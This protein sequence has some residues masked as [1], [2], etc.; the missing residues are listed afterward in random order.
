M[1]GGLT[2]GVCTADDIHIFVFAGGSFSVGRAVVDASTGE[3]VHAGDVQATPLHARRDH[4]TVANQFLPGPK[5]DHTILALH[6]KRLGL[7]RGKNFRAEPFDLRHAAT[8]QV[9]SA[10]P[11]RK[12]KVIFDARTEPGLAA[13]RLAL[14]QYGAKPLGTAIECAGESCRTGAND[15]DIIEIASWRSGETKLIG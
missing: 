13:G 7:N 8:R 12:A 1:N 5:F 14:N 3:T 10:E 11:R 15:N 6:K 2:C 4:H 9:G